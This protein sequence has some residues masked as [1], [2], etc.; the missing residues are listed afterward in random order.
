MIHPDNLADWKSKL[1]FTASIKGWPKLR[2]FSVM[3]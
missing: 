1:M 2:A 3:T